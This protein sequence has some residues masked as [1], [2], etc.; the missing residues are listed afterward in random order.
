MP[1]WKHEIRRRLANVNLDAA[2][3]DAIVDE[4]EQ[5]LADHYTEM[6]TGGATEAEAYQQTPAELQ[7]SELL[8][9][10]LRHLERQPHPESLVLG[11]NQRRNMIADL[12]QDLRFGARMLA[13][14]PGFT[15]IAVITLALGIGANTAIFS[16]AYAVLLRPLP[17]PAAERLVV[18]A[19][20][21]TQADYRTGVS[22]PDYLDWRDRTHSFDDTACFLNTSFNLTG[23]EPP[24]AV[25]GRRVNWNF[26]Q[27][28]GVKPQRGRLFAAS[29][30]QAGVVPTAVIS[31]GLWRE[32]FGG[33]D[34]ISGK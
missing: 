5:H 30:D 24:I 11:S 22:Y 25:S 8:W 16:V 1:E 33:D 13:K 2:R 17:Y 27:I 18:L 26:F 21:G 10:E 31:D 34:A 20:T 6:L 7:S 28:L 3:E 9:R 29:D 4:V 23:V 14:Q 12:W 32:K 15:L 19:T